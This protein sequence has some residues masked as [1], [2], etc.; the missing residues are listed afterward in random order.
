M[1]SNK[2]K[3]YV[4]IVIAYTIIGFNPLML[5]LTVG[6]VTALEIL[7]YR[8]TFAF[9]GTLI[10]II[11][12]KAK[13]DITWKD[14]RVLFP[15]MIVY[16]IVFFTLQTL[17]LEAIPSAEYGIIFALS[18]I[19][20]AVLASIFIKE[21]INRVQIL[22]IISSVSGVIFIMVMKGASLEV[23]N[24]RGIILSAL[25]AITLAVI[26]IMLRKVSGRYSAHTITFLVSATGFVTF[27]IAL[28]FVRISTGTLTQYFAPLADWRILMAALFL[29]VAGVFGTAFFQSYSL[30]Y[31]ESTK[32]VVFSNLAT[33]VTIFAG[34]IFLAESLYWYHLLGTIA[35][36][37]GVVGTNRFGNAARAKRMAKSAE[38]QDG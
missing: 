13:I 2:A 27:N 6:S 32:V 18:P 30:K 26:T 25:T 21:K 37:I 34:A 19:F 17:A 22:F 8:L 29:G 1:F 11:F 36:V 15:V 3:A 24:L 23:F 33:A 16:A 35:I 14:V 38:K 10:P 4:A 9:L 31:V 5:R 28:L 12:N 20:A 7:T